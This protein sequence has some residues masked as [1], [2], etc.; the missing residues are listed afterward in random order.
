MSASEAMD[1][2]A[3]DS[4]QG[5]SKGTD[6]VFDPRALEVEGGASGTGPQAAS[7]PE[8]VTEIGLRPPT[9]DE[10]VGQRPVVAN[11]RVHLEAALG[12]SEPPDHVLFCGP[13]GLG[14]TS[15]ARIL[16]EELG[17]DLQSTSGPALDKPRDL[18]GLLTN[19]KRG[20]VFF[21]DEIHRIP[22]GVEEYLYTAMEDFRVEMTLD[23]GPH[24]R[25]LP[26][27]VEPFTLVGATTREGLLSAPFRARFG[28]VER[29]DPYP[30]EDLVTILLRAARILGVELS[31]DGARLL[32]ER[33]RGTPRIASRFL[34]RARDRAQV[35]G[36]TRIDDVLA[37]RTLGDMGVDENGLE[38][39][40]RR[41][42]RCLAEYAPRASALKTIAAVVGETEDTI[43]DVFEPHLL[44]SGFLHKTPRGRVITGR[45]MEVIG[46][47]PNDLREPGGTAPLF[48]R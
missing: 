30:T 15:L 21:I 26:I 3:T 31:G 34:K 18:L 11:L 8:R 37:Q 32:A 25:V 13:P 1:S 28:L 5:P 39:M 48:D 44:R 42:L 38:E 14:K 10:F 27:N 16:S 29:L 2:E 24:A 12:R 45:G 6:H 7:A 46:L 36:T 19:L 43:E 47:D 35:A 33:S 22:I 4:E 20:D 17:S 40:D 41:I 9:L 23:S